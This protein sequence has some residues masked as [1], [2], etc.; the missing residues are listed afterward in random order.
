MSYSPKLATTFNNTK[1]RTEHNVSDISGMCSVC[2][3]QCIGLCEIGLSAVRGEEAAY[4][5]NTTTQQFASE[6]RYAIFRWGYLCPVPR[7]QNH[8]YR[9]FSQSVC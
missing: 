7:T 4:P 3:D 8:S 2:S 5:Y 9:D 6:K 1:L